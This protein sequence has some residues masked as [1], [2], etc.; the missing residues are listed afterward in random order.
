M[1]GCRYIKIDGI[2]SVCQ[3]F[4]TCADVKDIRESVEDVC[5]KMVELDS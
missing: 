5:N 2:R 1:I 4:K 3:E